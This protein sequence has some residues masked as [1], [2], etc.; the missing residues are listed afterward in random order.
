[1]TFFST[2][3]E[4]RYIFTKVSEQW[5]RAGVT[6]ALLVIRH[7]IFPIPGWGMLKRTDKLNPCGGS[8]SLHSEIEATLEAPIGCWKSSVYGND[9]TTLLIACSSKPKTHWRKCPRVL[10][11]GQQHQSPIWARL[12]RFITDQQ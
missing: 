11:T 12:R 2:I 6:F 10:K 7:Q 1:M 9:G 8:S 5:H 4:A 3:Y